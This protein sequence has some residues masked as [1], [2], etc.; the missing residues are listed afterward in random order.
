MPA[1]PDSHSACVLA[2]VA[3]A[4]A[5]TRAASDSRSGTRTTRLMVP[6]R[7]TGRAASGA[8]AHVGCPSPTVADTSTPESVTDDTARTSAAVSMPT[9]R[10]GRPRD[11]PSF[12]RWWSGSRRP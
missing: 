1:M 7:L 6:T 4:M 5:F 12:D 2:S 3:V 10:P 8:A 9:P 11:T